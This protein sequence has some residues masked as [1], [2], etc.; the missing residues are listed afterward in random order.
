MKNNPNAPL[1]NHNL[2]DF[3]FFSANKE[4][5][6]T[7][8]EIIV[9]SQTTTGLIVLAISVGILKKSHGAAKTLLKNNTRVIGINKNF[10]KQNH[11]F[12]V[13]Y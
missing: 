1:T 4:T 3:F 6:T 2:C 8:R 12:P 10:F 11:L 5:T 9:A 13:Y 7:I